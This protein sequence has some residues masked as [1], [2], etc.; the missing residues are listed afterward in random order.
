[1][2]MIPKSLP[3]VTPKISQ[4]TVLKPKEGKTGQANV[5]ARNECVPTCNF[6]TVATSRLGL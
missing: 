5:K 1:M 3:L 6:M 4:D 2:L